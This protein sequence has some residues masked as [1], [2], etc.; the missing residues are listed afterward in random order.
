VGRRVMY[1]AKEVHALLNGG[2][3]GNPKETL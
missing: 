1:K 3:D 2:S